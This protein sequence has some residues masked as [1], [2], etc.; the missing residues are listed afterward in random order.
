MVRYCSDEA[1]RAVSELRDEPH[2]DVSLADRLRQSIDQLTGGT[3]L[4]LRFEM[5]GKLPPCSSELSSDL[6]RICQEATA[7]ALRHAFASELV[8]RVVCGD[9]SIS[10][11]VED[12]GVGMDA[13]A[14]EHP[15]HG[16]YGL[17]GM[18]ERAQR[19]GG[20]LYL[21]SQPGHGTTVRAVVPIGR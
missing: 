5:K 15:P 13:S 8:V 9:E 7:N 3:A 6:L 21:S 20:N 12:D 11:S 1:R 18:R 10:L 16:H 14:I 2:C 17:L 19:S 4:R